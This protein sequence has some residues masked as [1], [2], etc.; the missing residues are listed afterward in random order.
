MISNLVNDYV[1]DPQARKNLVS[2]FRNA[3]TL[4]CESIVSKSHNES[5]CKYVTIVF[6]LVG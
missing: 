5:I 2:G 6:S 1:K 3:G 4:F